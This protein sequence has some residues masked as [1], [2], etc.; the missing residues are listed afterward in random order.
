MDKQ[1]KKLKRVVIKEELVALTGDYIKALILNQFI[2]WSERTGEFD[3]FITEERKR[4]PD[5]V[6]DL[7]YGWIY[8][9][10]DELI[11]ELMLN[12]SANTVRR[13]LIALEEMGYL[14]ERRNPKYKWDRV[15]Q[16]RPDIVKIQI[17]LHNLG[18]ALADYPLTHANSTLKG[19][20]PTLKVQT[21]Q[22][23][24]AIP[25][26]TTEITNRDIS[27]EK[28]LSES[29]PFSVRTETLS[30][31]AKNSETAKTSDT[32]SLVPVFSD[33]NV[34]P[35]MGNILEKMSV[36]GLVNYKLDGTNP[37]WSSFRWADNG[38]PVE[39]IPYG[40]A[41]KYGYELP[42]IQGVQENV[43]VDTRT[44]YEVGEE[45]HFGLG[46]HP[47]VLAKYASK[48][49][50]AA[51]ET[52]DK[53]IMGEDV[54]EMGALDD[55]FGENPR[56]D[57]IDA[58]QTAPRMTPEELLL[59]SM[60]AG[61]PGE[62]RSVL[63]SMRDRGWQV[64]DERV[65]TVLAQF[66]EITGFEIPSNKAQRKLFEVGARDHLDEA[67]FEG[68][69]G[70]L[71]KVVWDSVLEDVSAGDLVLTHPRAFSK[72]M[73]GA[74][75]REAGRDTSK[76]PAGGLTRNQVLHVFQNKGL[77]KVKEIEGTGKH[78]FFW[79]DTGEPVDKKLPRDL[80]KKHILNKSSV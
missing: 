31:N 21:L 73:Y 58:H 9:K 28:K 46:P 55:V 27:L 8:K 10:T 51:A 69:I 80:I 23:D 35:E 77:V 15:L 18:Y 3:Q 76:G 41:K 54:P 24:V 6:I 13:H 20:N 78:G 52:L 61:V 36:D 33:N 64:R 26:T 14:S 39:N 7:S 47:Q 44:T 70:E 38:L 40:I 32:P 60:G 71:Y 56:Q 74:V 11:D 63:A 43:L 1:P 25:E 16:Y 50:R 72:L 29:E 67:L 79:T 42:E 5:A 48:V 62:I 17:D 12:I 65:E 30:A 45:T 66:F 68:R 4:D 37:E 75:N 53:E 34:I 22:N 49:A 57:E 19:R 2:Y 59:A